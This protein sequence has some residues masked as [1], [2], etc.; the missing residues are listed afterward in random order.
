MRVVRQLVV[1]ESAGVIHYEADEDVLRMVEFMAPCNSVRCARLS[2]FVRVASPSFAS[3][4]TSSKNLL[5]PA[6]RRGA[7]VLEQNP[8]PLGSPVLLPSGC[9]APMPS[10]SG[11]GRQ[12][13]S[14][15]TSALSARLAQRNSP[16]SIDLRCTASGSMASF[17]RAGLSRNHVV[18]SVPL[19]VSHA[20]ENR[21]AP[22][23][24][25]ALPC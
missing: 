19:A 16:M 10:V 24:V 22:S 23:Q 12:R 11:Q 5:A 17:P 7:D 14:L 9:Q 25:S 20:Y 3:I 8:L 18:S 2:L 4:V 6:L 13:F 15:A 21:G 1:T